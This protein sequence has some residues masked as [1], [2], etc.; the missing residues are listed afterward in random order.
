MIKQLHV[1]GRENE[2]NIELKNMDQEVLNLKIPLVNRYQTCFSWDELL[3]YFQY[4]CILQ[5]W[6]DIFLMAPCLC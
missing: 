2:V 3:D 4:K 1:V 6:Q 5:T